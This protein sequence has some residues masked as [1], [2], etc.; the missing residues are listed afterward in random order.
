MA[1]NPTI[2]NFSVEFIE[3]ELQRIPHLKSIDDLTF[4]GGVQKAFVI[5]ANDVTKQMKQWI[6]SDVGRPTNLSESISPATP[7]TNG[8]I[9]LTDLS[10]PEYWSYFNYGVD[11]LEGSG[12]A[13]INEDGFKYQFNLPFVTKSHA[14]AIE[15]WLPSTG[16][17]GGL[18]S[19]NSIFYAIAMNNKKRGLK[20][21]PFVESIMTQETI[22]FFGKKL[23]EIT[24][25]HFEVVW[26]T[27]ASEQSKKK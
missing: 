3:Q 8:K 2:N 11:P 1:I 18:D 4:T 5:W 21:R 6:V 23:F 10:A 22:D 24:G 27:E 7:V 14:E 26:N 12:K 25:K 9:V 15:K 20:A 19:Y 16:R 13:T 17:F